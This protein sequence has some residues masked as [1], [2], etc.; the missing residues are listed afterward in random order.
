MKVSGEKQKSSK[1]FFFQGIRARFSKKKSR[2]NS[3]IRSNDNYAESKEKFLEQLFMIVPK[4]MHRRN[5]KNCECIFKKIPDKF[6]GRISVTIF[7]FF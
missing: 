5:F 7:M 2:E 6:A 3:S 4:Y 1:G